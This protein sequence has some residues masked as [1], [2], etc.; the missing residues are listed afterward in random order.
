MRRRIAELGPWLYPFDFGDGL[1]APL[2]VTPEVGRIHATRLAMLEAKARSHFGDR[3]PG[4][5]C[6]DVGC[7]EGFFSLALARM[8]AR[9]AAVDPR[10]ENL[11]RARFVIE[12]LGVRNVRLR[13]GRVE[14]LARDEART[15]DLTILFG[16]LYH[17]EDPMLCLRQMAAVTGDLCL[18]ETQVVE[19]VEG[20]VEWGS[21]EWK[22]PY[23]GILAL[24]DDS[25]DVDRGA[26]QTGLTSMAVCPSVK[27]L[28]FML[29]TAGFAR[30]EIL[31]PPAG[32]YEQH[33]RGRRVVCAAYR[34]DPCLARPG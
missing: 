2:A 21:S 12:A 23:H 11:S 32:A 19:E 25:T 26:R 20:W 30:A 29:R 33:A 22:H 16:V 28:L 14:T 10:A 24:V 8:A 31:D 1:V 34:K 27:A 5:E 3:L 4:I 7:H 15:Y 17:V 6:L 13:E 18:I 9:V